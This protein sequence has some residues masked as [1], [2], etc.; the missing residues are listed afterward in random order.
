M[1]YTSSTTVPNTVEKPAWWQF[2]KN[3]QPEQY[4]A[5]VFVLPAVLLLVTFRL[6]PMVAGVGYS[7]TEWD[8]FTEPVFIG[9]ANY[10]ELIMEDQ[11][12]HASIR[13]ALAM[14]LALPIMVSFPLLIAI[15]IHVGVPGS[16]FF[17]AAYFFPAVLSSV[18]I[19]AIFTILLRF[20]G[21]LNE[22]LAAFN[23]AAID[24]LGSSQSALISVI[25]VY[26]WATFG[27][28]VLIFLSGLSTV[29]QD[30]FDAAHVDG[31]N[32]WQTLRFVIIPVLQPII[33]FVAIITT[34]NMLSGMFGL[35]FVMTGGGPGTATYLPEY[36]IYLQQGE[37]NRPGYAA[38]TS[39]LLFLALGII[40]LLQIR[41]M[42]RNSKV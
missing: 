41:F 23:V 22:F 33:E 30:L 5:Y 35:I 29:P 15:A 2:W 8:G 17:R 10:V 1:Q 42:S 37:F 19:G 16:S 6:L 9:L 25:I 32:F 40:A 38:A 39:V 3:R 20:D 13:N 4:M 28:S 14:L 34:I 36:L 24:W 27:I 21:P 26:I 7:L 12:F 18:I 31:A 11:L